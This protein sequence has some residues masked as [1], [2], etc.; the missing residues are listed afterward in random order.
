[1]LPKIL[2]I[3][4]FSYCW[5][6]H[7]RCSWST[8]RDI[9]RYTKRRNL[10]ITIKPNSCECCGP[11]LSSFPVPVFVIYPLYLFVHPDSSQNHESQLA[12]ISSLWLF[13]S[14][15]WTQWCV[16]VQAWFHPYGLG[17]W[18]LT[19]E[20][21]SAIYIVETYQ[22]FPFINRKTDQHETMNLLT[23]ASWTSHP[24]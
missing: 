4:K 12:W 17:L 1:M 16:I 21:P 11:C 5:I 7:F 10:Q 24:P 22:K 18:K 15:I 6:T 3:G 8:Y 14:Y 13:H 2:Y 19:R 23:S 9:F 20:L